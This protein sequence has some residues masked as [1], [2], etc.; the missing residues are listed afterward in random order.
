MIP[1]SPIARPIPWDCCVSRDKVR[2]LIGMHFIPYWKMNMHGLY[3][4]EM[5]LEN[6]VVHTHLARGQPSELAPLVPLYCRLQTHQEPAAGLEDRWAHEFRWSITDQWPLF[7]STF[8][9]LV[10]HPASGLLGLSSTS[11]LTPRLVI[12]L[13]G[14][15]VKWTNKRLVIPTLKL[16]WSFWP[17]SYSKNWF[18]NVPQLWQMICM[19]WRN[20]EVSSLQ[21]QSSTQNAR[22]W[23]FGLLVSEKSHRVPSSSSGSE[24]FKHPKIPYGKSPY[25]LATSIWGDQSPKDFLHRLLAPKRPLVWSS[26]TGEGALG[27]GACWPWPWR[28][29][30]F[31]GHGATP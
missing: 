6:Q 23:N 27:R 12:F 7:D 24:N 22:L 21:P 30:A 10:R 18:R 19:I 1:L 28:A 26:G 3:S 11:V 17:I 8:A 5:A 16:A 29:M 15:E 25:Q 9:G 31:H 20:H 13:K 2:L 4:Y 14:Q